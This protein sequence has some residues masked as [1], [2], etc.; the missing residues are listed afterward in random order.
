MPE[1]QNIKQSRGTRSF[2]ERQIIPAKQVHVSNPAAIIQRA[3][4]DPKSIT[5]A[6]VLQLQRTIGNRAV[7]RLLSEIRN[8][9][10]AQQ[11]PIQRQEISEEEETCPSCVQKHE[12]Q[13]EKEPLQG[14]FENKPE[15]AICPSCMQRQEIPE[16]KSL[17]TKNEN[18]TEMS[19]NLKAGVESLSGIDMSDVR[20]HYNSDKP[21]EVGALAYTQGINI[22]IAPGQER[23]LPHE[24]WHVVQQA[25]GRVK[26]TKQMRK[27]IAV[28]DDKELEREADIMGYKSLQ[29]C[30]QSE[31]RDDKISR[32][33][34]SFHLNSDNNPSLIRR[35]EEYVEQR[36]N[37]VQCLCITKNAEVKT[38]AET[39]FRHRRNEGDA[40]NG[41][42]NYAFN[43]NTGVYMKSASNGH[44]EI[45]LL[46]L[47]K[48]D[49]DVEIVSE[50]TPCVPC[51]RDMSLF[52]RVHSVNVTV[53]YNTQYQDSGN[54]NIESILEHYKE[55][56]YIK[57]PRNRVTYITKKGRDV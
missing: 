4:I 41:A 8:S 33:V 24:A 37:V 38:D 9:F 54:G 3:R 21:A 55:L 12:I 57:V 35:R 22:H 11:I 46:T 43:V 50:L 49:K 56:G 14:M 6:D 10:T 28:N 31:K 45:R 1:H 16:D 42:H 19:D 26:P 29:M 23:H 13:E 47:E 40:T 18:N 44:A 36:G 27:G 5:S 17:Q 20:V 51:Q 48:G 32:Y 30:T 39:L 2:S 7:G 15:K 25:Q 34:S 53:Y 52:E